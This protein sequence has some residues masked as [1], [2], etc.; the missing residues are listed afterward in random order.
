[1]NKK[2]I[3]ETV[4]MILVLAA[5]A[6]GISLFITQPTDSPTGL[7][8]LQQ[9]FPVACDNCPT[10]FNPNQSDVDSDGVGDACDNCPDDF[11]PDQEDSNGNGII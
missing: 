4:V 11:N 2:A 3:V 7:V 5:A 9:T 8:S 1:M 10:D 6:I